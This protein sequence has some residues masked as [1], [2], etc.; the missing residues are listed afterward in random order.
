M[1]P[2]RSPLNADLALR[3]S[4]PIAFTHFCHALQ[5]MRLSFCLWSLRCS[6]SLYQGTGAS[7]I[8]AEPPSLQESLSATSP[9][10]IQLNH[11]RLACHIKAYT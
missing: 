9:P 4:V 5:D 2:Q 6:P 1:G 3:E 11:V 8:S 10:F 7:F